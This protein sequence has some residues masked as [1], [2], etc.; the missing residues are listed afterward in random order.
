MKKMY[1]RMSLF[2]LLLIAGHVGWTQP[3]WL[4]NYYA[5]HGGESE[6][7]ND[8]NFYEVQEWA[9]NYFEEAENELEKLNS[10][11]SADKYYANPMVKHYIKYKRWEAY[12]QDHIMD[13]GSLGH[14]SLDVVKDINAKKFPS[15]GSKKSA[16]RPGDTWSNISPEGFVKPDETNHFGIGRVECID[17]HPTNPN[18]FWIGTVGGGIW[19]T[20]DGGNTYIPLGDDLPIM[21]VVRI[22][23]NKQ[24]PD[25]IIIALADYGD[26][27]YFLGHQRGMGIYRSLNGGQTF[28]PT[29]LSTDYEDGSAIGDMVRSP[30]NN[31]IVLLADDRGIHRSTD[32]GQTWTQTHT[33]QAYDLAWKFDGTG[34]TIFA[35]A[36]FNGVDRVLV[37][38]NAGV[39]WSNTNA[40]SN[41]ISRSKITTSKVNPNL[42]VFWS[43]K[44]RGFVDVYVSTNGG[45]N[46]V[47]RTTQ[48]RAEY[49]GIYLSAVDEN[50]MYGGHLS[51]YRSQNQGQSYD[52]ITS[53]V[54]SNFERIHADQRYIEA[55]PHDADLVYFCNDGGVYTYRES[56][57]QW[58]NLSAGLSITQYHDISVS[59]VNAENYAVA[60]QDNGGAY[61]VPGGNW[62]ASVSADV[63]RS[64]AH[65]TDA[66]TFYHYQFGGWF[67]KFTNGVWKNLTPPKV[68]ANGQPIRNNQGHIQY[69]VLGFY[70]PLDL[71]PDDPQKFAIA[72]DK[73]YYTTDEAATWDTISGSIYGGDIRILKFAPSNPNMIY[74]CNG[75]RLNRTTNLGQDGWPQR[76][77]LPADISAITVD[78][79]NENIVYVTLSGWSAGNK[80]KRSTD[81]GAT[82]Q[83]LS[84]GIDNVPV[85]SFE[86]QGGAE[87]RM[88][89]GTEYGVM[90]RDNGLSQWEFYSSGLPNVAVRAIEIQN[91]TNQIYV[92]TYGRGIWRAP[93]NPVTGDVDADHDGF[94]I[95]VDCNDDNAAINPGATEI[96]GNEI[97][98]NCDGSDGGSIGG[99]PYQGTPQVIPGLVEAE[100]YDEDGAGVA[101]FD[102]DAGNNGR[103]IR[104]DDVDV[105]FGSSNG[106]VGWIANGE[107]LHYTVNVETT[108]IYTIETAVA[109]INS[110]TSFNLELDGQ[111]LTGSVSVPNTGNWQT[112]QTV[113][114]TGIN[115]SAGIHVLRFN[116]QANGFNVDEFVFTLEGNNE[117][118]IVAAGDFKQI[119]LPTNSVIINDAT[120]FDNDGTIA[121]LQ[122]SQDAGPNTATITNGTTIEPTFSGLVEGL[123]DFRLTATD[124]DGASNFGT[125]SV[126]V[127]PADNQAP[128]VGAGDFKQI[129]LPTNSVTIDDATAFDNDGTIASLQWS[130]DAGP[131]TATIA[132]GNTIEP[133]FSGL[134]EGLYEFRL[135][136]TDNDGASNFGTVS[137]RV[138]PADNQAPVV[139]AG[140]FK[141]ITLP[142]N[143]VIIDDATAFD[144]DGTIASLQWTQDSGPNTATIGN[145]T[146]IEPTISGLVA[147]LYE[148]R[149]TATDNDGASNFGTV[150]VR[151][152]PADNQAPVVGAGDFKQITLPTNSVII[153]DATAFDN[154]GTIA[155]LQWTQDSGPNT[156]TIGNATTIEPTISG[157]VA[158][159][160]E[161]RL[162]ATDNDGA[163]NFGTV[164]VRVNPADNQAPVVGAGDFKQITLPTNSIII[165]DATAFD[166]DGT[167]ASLQWSQDAGPNTATVTNGTTIEPTF[168]GLVE[169]L[170]EFRL[171]ATDNDGASNF[172][173]VSVRVHPAASSQTPYNGTA[174]VIPGLVEAEFYDED[175]AGV[176]YFDTDA[177]NNGRAI[178][179]DDVDVEFGS[180]NGNVGWIANGEWLEYTVDVQTTGSYNVDVRVASINSGTSFNLELDGQSLTG[181]INVPNTGNWQTYQTVSATGLQMTAGTHILRFNALANG[182][183]V[184]DYV[185]AIGTTTSS[186][187]NDNDGFTADVDCDDNNPAVNPG[188][189]EICDEIDNDCDGEIDEGVQTQFFADSDRDGWGANNTW[190]WACSNPGNVP[191]AFVLISGDCNDSHSGIN[192]GV[193]E[194]PGNGFDDNC[195][196]EI[197][198]E[199]GCEV[200]AANGEYTLSISENGNQLVVDWDGLAGMGNGFVFMDQWVDGNYRGS[201]SA[202]VDFGQR[203]FGLDNIAQG[204]TVEF[205]FKYDRPG[206]Q[207]VGARTDHSYTM[208]ECAGVAKK[209]VTTEAVSFSLL[210]NP[211]F[212]E[213]TIE[214]QGAN[215]LKA[216]IIGNR[217]VVN[218][219]VIGSGNTMKVDVSDLAT[220][221]YTVQ[222]ET[223]SGIEFVRF[224]KM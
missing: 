219:P 14:V 148:F 184:D 152:N 139:G 165:D 106:N 112:Y 17:F 199:A 88:Y 52:Q 133:T 149:L 197:D 177:G 57:Q 27:R 107:W 54:D 128:V 203:I 117:A 108:G 56:T 115:M 49:G 154:D 80:V 138:N 189:T 137:V 168:S 159:L 48:V 224:V 63:T 45:S 174:Q 35:T 36:R 158:G 71:S 77:V 75:R 31:Q 73:V 214:A 216:T 24:N 85:L 47:Q 98:E 19:K 20:E 123:Y 205:F 99:T 206:G 171:T 191:E 111:A 39:S 163:S 105:E 160:Y 60:S 221:I 83:D 151:V 69:R 162:T 175:G 104:N 120:A 218:S 142:T 119:T 164:S 209:A 4:K 217:G 18:I 192:P 172:G 182:F 161:F 143:S 193:A 44:N 185:F 183:N 12:W 43:I 155:S 181:T 33:G 208:G 42:V 200:E 187:D 37:S 81:G 220:G 196:G 68:D 41:N 96:P 194:I 210:P 74:V 62:T 126:R 97:D 215:I 7:Q 64:L 65:P 92:G 186:V 26:S 30:Q 121:S 51:I 145:A 86:L 67:Y 28:E 89:I 13:D 23:V 53:W 178:R 95:S 78:P 110:G 101:Y 140:D 166:N 207:Y 29:S 22:S 204:S 91:Q 113:T 136:A 125:V 195:D 202:S 58:T 9:H 50:V 156:A 129:T 124:D 188:A 21:K 32:G 211:A 3:T 15:T 153:D 55:S 94:G 169:G 100:F 198:E 144:N 10:T 40:S 201:F 116:A 1:T 103:A 82:W 76:S 213:I 59:Q 134:V 146:T 6:T 132:S 34:N 170:Y 90:Y 179:N 114:V 38:T 72:D 176:A 87:N 11:N 61:H 173:T 5:S 8:L 66:N 109:S 93:V 141:Q 79:N 167:I 118:P 222:I 46:F 190:V 212:D 131:N 2:M 122:W 16:A 223:I 130:Q 102:T 150:S 25:D 157:L 147:G 70:G 84:E 127:N 180:S 135:T